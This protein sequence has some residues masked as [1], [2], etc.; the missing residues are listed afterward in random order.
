MG[1]GA[2]K[3][4]F[5]DICF[6]VRLQGRDVLITARHDL[7][8]NT[9]SIYVDGS[10]TKTKDVHFT[11]LPGSL[12]NKLFRLRFDLF[13]GHKGLLV[14]KKEN[15]NYS[16]FFDGKVVQRL[17]VSALPGSFAD[18]VVLAWKVVQVGRVGEYRVLFGTKSLKI[19]VNSRV[20]EATSETVGDKLNMTWALPQL[21]R[22]GEQEN[23]PVDT[24]SD[25]QLEMFILCKASNSPDTGN[26]SVAAG[27]EIG[28]LNLSDSIEI[29]F[30]FGA[31]RLDDCS[32]AL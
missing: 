19:C 6:R 31:D 8:N 16:L 21:P 4:R 11:T 24:R 7:Q 25:E 5:A 18:E 10:P 23:A 14:F 28:A 12:Q 30:V 29:R 15:N 9:V 22:D 3:G 27:A 26:S 2:G 32:V 1:N 20:V 13:E 17:D